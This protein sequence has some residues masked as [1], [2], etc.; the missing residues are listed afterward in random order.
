[1]L[2]LVLFFLVA[3]IRVACPTERSDEMQ[4][5]ALSQ[6]FIDAWN[7]ADA[8]DLATQFVADG[9]LITP[10]GIRSHGRASIRAFYNGAFR[11][12]YAGSIAGITFVAIRPVAHEVMILDGTW[13]IANARTSVGEP[14]P[15]EQGIA[16]MIVVKT[17]RGWRVSAVR[18][19]SNA[20]AI[21]DIS[22][23]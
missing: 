8:D 7:R 16:T 17:N 3:S 4:V 5:R 10:D 21:R 12:G 15:R 11:R 22:T 1:M 2:G 19:Q 23:P 13:F 9:D 6:R 14:A 18:E 20:S